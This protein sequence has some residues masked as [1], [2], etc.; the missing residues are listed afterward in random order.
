MHQ[1]GDCFPGLAVHR[2]GSS[3]DGYVRSAE[4]V[5]EGLSLQLPAA[6]QYS[7][8]FIQLSSTVAALYSSALQL[9]LRT[10][11]QYRDTERTAAMVTHSAM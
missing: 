2:C 6:Q 4:Q 10:A 3:G 8:S 5:W 1:H 9:Q 11:Q 7:C